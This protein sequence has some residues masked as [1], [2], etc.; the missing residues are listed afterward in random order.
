MFFGGMS[1]FTI[2]LIVWVIGYLT[3][4]RKYGVPSAGWCFT[5]MI[6]CVVMSVGNLLSMLG[7]NL[8][9]AVFLL[10]TVPG[11]RH[12]YLLWQDQW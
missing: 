2:A 4:E 3:Q 7:G 5:L 12:Y 6:C 8:I 9:G 1:I 10:F 11:I